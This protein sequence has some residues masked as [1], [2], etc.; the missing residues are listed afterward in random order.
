MG[1]SQVK[2]IWLY[3]FLVVIFLTIILTSVYYLLGGFEEVEVF[4]LE[5]E[6]KNIAGIEFK[7]KYNEPRLEEISN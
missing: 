5:G 2:Q 1:T 3:G 7:G 4:D 6:T